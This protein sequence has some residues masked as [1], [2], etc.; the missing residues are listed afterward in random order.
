MKRTSKLLINCFIFS[1][2][3]FSALNHINAEI[4]K[5]PVSE[6]PDT[7][8]KNAIAIVREDYTEVA[9]IDKS[10][11]KSKHHYVITILNKNADELSRMRFGYDKL[12]KLISCKAFI[13][14][15]DGKTMKKIKLSD[16]DDYSNV[17]TSEIFSDDRVKVYTP[18]VNKYPYTVEM[19]VEYENHNLMLPVYWTSVDYYDVSVQKSGLKYIVSNNLQIKYK[20]S[21]LTDSMQITKINGKVEYYWNAAN[22]KA[23]EKEP[24]SV[25][26]IEL[27]P[28]SKVA[29]YDFNVENYSGSS[30]SWESLSKFFYNVSKS[31]NKLSDKTVNEIKD[32][33]RN[34]ATTREKVKKVYE[35]MQSKTRYIAIQLGIGGYKPFDASVVDKLGYGDCKA[36]TNYTKSL[37][38]TLGIKSVY[39]IIKAGR[40]EYSIDKEFVSNQFN[41][42]ILCIPDQE[43]TIWLECTS[44]NN[45]FDFQGEFTGDR[46]ALLICE[47]DGKLVNTTRYTAKQNLQTHI[48]EVNLDNTGSGKASIT[49]QFRGIQYDNRDNITY[50]NK[51]DQKKWLYENMNIPNFVITDFDYSNNKDNGPVITEELELNLL[52][53]AA[54]S[55]KRIFIPLNMLN[56]TE[57]TIP[58]KKER[59]T[60]LR[61]NYP[62]NDID[63]ISYSIPEGLKVESI[64][65]KKEIVNDFGEYHSEVKVQDNKILYVRNFIKY[66]GTFNKKRYADYIDFMKQI[67]NADNIK[68]ALIK[69]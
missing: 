59:L 17:G 5:Y 61:F 69:L 68:V 50:F 42:V 45:P 18:I 14:D 37:L 52:N 1:I 48:A 65:E 3:I 27:V 55:G 19:E 34:I 15:A 21:H 9:I 58:R 24:F 31:D 41:H 6:I 51:D 11:G 49:S 25:G 53:Y 43:D 38:D 4:I 56:K 12:A 40:G 23:I 16:F 32:I 54:A 28:S 29:L 64:P 62:F 46:Q 39:T 26:L 7:L 8:K 36:L 35:Y 67:N 30:D 57:F 20:N 47:D 13:Y 2:L 10:I 63:S 33:T 66:K 22:I 44:Q 60:S